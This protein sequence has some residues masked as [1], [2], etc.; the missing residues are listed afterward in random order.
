[1][2]RIADRTVLFADLRGSTALFETLGN[3]EA[4]SVV[5]HCVNALAAPVAGQRGHVVKTLGDG[6]MAVFDTPADG[7][8]RRPWRCTTCSRAWSRAAASAAPRRACAGCRLQVGLAR[9]EVVEMARRLLRRRRQRGGAAA[10]PCRATTRRCSPRRCSAACRR[11]CSRAFA[12]STGWC[13]AGASSRWRCMCMGGRRG[14]IDLGGDAVRRRLQRA[15]TRGLR[16]IWGGLQR[17][18]AS[19]QMP[20]VLG[21]S[22]QATFCVDDCACLA[23]ARTRRLA[24]RQLPAHRPQLQRHLRALQRRR[25]R[26]PAPRQ[27]HACTA[28]APSA[29]AARPPTPAPPCVSFDVL[30]FARYAAAGA[31]GVALDAAGALRR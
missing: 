8:A 4:T 28:A 1:M 12:A 20:V 17:V 13:C 10:R 21:R 29:W 15:G 19:Q 22:P 9:G 25:D 26:Q 27:L 2:T 16:L 18:F 31:A 24:Q 5:T 14:G 7:R 6:L 11:S 30:H 3:A 23:F